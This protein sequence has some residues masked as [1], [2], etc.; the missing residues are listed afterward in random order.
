VR[1][2]PG[3]LFL[4]AL[5]RTSPSAGPAVTASAFVPDHDHHRG[6]FV[7]RA[8]PLFLDAAG[9]RVNV[10][11]GL[12]AALSAR[13]S[14][15]VSGE[16]V[17]AYVAA[18]LAH[19]VYTAH[20]HADLLTPGLRV[21]LTANAAS[22]ADAVALGRR[23]LWLHTYGR[24]FADAAAGRPA[25]APR[26]VQ[27]DRPLVVTPIPDSPDAMPE[28]IVH[29]PALAQLRVG[30][31][32]IEGV[33]EPVWDYEVSGFRVVKRWFDRRK[34]EPEGNR[35]SPLD[36]LVATS[37]EPEWTEELIDLL[38]VLRL[39]VDLEPQQADLLDQV[40]AG[41][42]VTTEELRAAVVLPST[43]ITP[44]RDRPTPE[45]PARQSQL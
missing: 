40:L 5:D 22:F 19:P 42:M 4:T 11:A 2:A 43:D 16:D 27:G 32:V 8:F 6:S 44:A 45:K 30:A 31:G 21:P 14:R 3:Q 38:N 15:S 39:L 37:W 9:E 36:H 34:R 26:V 1:T 13:L 35:S 33:P 41:P 12:L 20:F 23:V 10:P 24:C 7:G 17:K 25:G 28:E 29:D 18:L